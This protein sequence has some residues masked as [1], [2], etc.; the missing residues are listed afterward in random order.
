MGSAETWHALNRLY[1]QMLVCYVVHVNRV[2][3]EDGVNFWGGSEV[4]A[5]DGTCVARAPD[6][7]EALIVADLPDSRLRPPADPPAVA[8]GPEH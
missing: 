3:F 5:P 7:E 2:G 6:F 4:V 1:A 8:P